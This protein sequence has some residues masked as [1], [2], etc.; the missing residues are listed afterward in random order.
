MKYFIRLHNSWSFKYTLMGVKIFRMKITDFTM[1][2][3]II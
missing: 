1:N 3:N 2:L